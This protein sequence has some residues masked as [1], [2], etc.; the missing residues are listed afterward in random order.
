MIV[1]RCVVVVV[2]LEVGTGLDQPHI[3]A[4]D[5]SQ[6]AKVCVSVCVCACACVCVCACACVRVHVR[7]YLQTTQSCLQCTHTKQVNREHGHTTC[8][9]YIKPGSVAPP[10]PPL[11]LQHVIHES[12][13][14]IRV[15]VPGELNSNTAGQQ[16]EV[17][18]VRCS[19]C[20]FSYSSQQLRH[21]V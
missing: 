12:P 17:H 7:T 14:H 15:T 13:Y 2:Q 18:L 10:P 19:C 8:T 21:V 16:L 6:C 9:Q 3:L 5:N 20:L 4:C 11:T 1:W